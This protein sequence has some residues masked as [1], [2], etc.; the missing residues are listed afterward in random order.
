MELS[1]T[2]SIIIVA[3]PALLA[4]A[5]GVAKLAG[6]KAVVASL[7][8]VGFAQWSAYLGLAE[9]GF[10]A[11]LL[12]PATN[13]L[14]F[15]LLAC[16]FSGALAVDISYRNKFVAPLFILSLLFIAELIAYGGQWFG[17]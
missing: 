8:K 13:L 7:E 15:V 17:N 1:S 9:I 10:A 4:I 16:Y 5:S 12:V 3:I 11:L 6:A 14:G 2:W